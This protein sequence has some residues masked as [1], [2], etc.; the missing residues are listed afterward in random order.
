M[1]P[2]SQ[3]I[4]LYKLNIYSAICQLYPNKTGRKKRFKTTQKLL[5]ETKKG[6]IQTDKGYSQKVF[7]L[8]I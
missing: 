6:R 7:L 5:W 3:I 8:K 2:V 1:M 4:M